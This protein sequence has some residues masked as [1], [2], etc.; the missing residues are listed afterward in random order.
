MTLY[1]PLQMAADLPE[2][3]AE[4]MDAFQ[5]IKDVAVDWEQSRYLIAE[6]GEELVIA[7]Q[8][9]KESLEK[10]AKGVAALKD[11]KKD[12]VNG[13]TRFSKG[14]KDVWFVG[15]VTD[16]KDREVTF[17]LDFLK[18]GS[19]YEAILYR[20]APDAD[21]TCGIQADGSNPGQRYVIETKTVTSADS[22]T[23]W[24]ARSGGFAVSLKEK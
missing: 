20:D 10:A 7:R 23:V 8:V 13:S 14:D 1:S 9:R 4:H 15:G 3:Y 5:F 2:Y 16:E 22:L 24:M 11:G 21:G 18:E 17:P 19:E 6:P 12:F